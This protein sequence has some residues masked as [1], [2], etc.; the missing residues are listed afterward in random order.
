MRTS[1]INT[2]A[3]CDYRYGGNRS[4]GSTPSSQKVIQSLERV[5]TPAILLGVRLALLRKKVLAE[6]E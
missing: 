3:A 6:S 5:F 4:L 2:E 1:P